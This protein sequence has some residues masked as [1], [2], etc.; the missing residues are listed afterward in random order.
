MKRRNLISLFAGVFMLLAGAWSDGY[1]QTASNGEVFVANDYRTSGPNNTIVVKWFA[2]KVYY[3]G[4]FDVYRREEG[5]TSWT[6]LNTDPVKVKTT[7]PQQLLDDK[8]AKAL[9]D[10]VNNTSYDE[11]QK[12]VGKVFVAIKAILTPLFAEQLGIIY[13]DASAEQ[14]RRYEYQVRGLSSGAEEIVNVSQ[15]ISPGSFQPQLP[16]QEVSV[17]RT[18]NGVAINWKPEELRYYGVYVYRRSAT[19]PTW[20]QLNALP[21][22][23]YKSEDQHGNETY[24][25]VFYLDTDIK[26]EESYEYKLNGVDFFGQLT[27]DTETFSAPVVDFHAPLSPVNL[28]TSINVMDLTLSWGIQPDEDL[29]GFRVYRS[30]HSDSTMRPV[31]AGLLSKETNSYTDRLLK[32]GGYYYEVAAVDSAGNEGRSQRIFIEVRDVTPPA[33]PKNVFVSPDTGRIVLTWR[34]NEEPDL[35]GY[36]VYRSIHDGNHHDDEFIVMNTTPLTTTTYTEILPKNVKT[37]FVYAVVAEDLSYNRSKL[38]DVSVVK[39]PDVTPPSKPVM[40]NIEVTDNTL[41][42]EWLP[43]ADTDLAGYN[44]FRS[45]DS[46]AFSKLNANPYPATSARFT[47][48]MIEANQRYYYYV[49][50][51][52]SAGNVSVPSNIYTALNKKLS[53]I[54]ITPSDVRAEYAKSGKQVKISW[55]LPGDRELVGAVI[56][57]SIDGENFR[58]VTGVIKTTDFADKEVKPGRT[59]YYQVRSY[60]S[61][62][63]VGKSETLVATI[64]E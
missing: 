13:Y 4:G 19:D 8:D 51:I 58:P 5:T 35:R 23:V 24:P 64:K 20:K 10:M 3:P 54:N 38:S 56:Y 6:K 49:Q 60:T 43:N 47:D 29:T 7:V 46:V 26:E 9:L 57:K 16:P 32:T 15:A 45:T 1:A 31:H 12:G 28:Q 62:G 52:D 39:M 63:A 53:S 25:E 27:G 17:S 50:A 37:K 42:L 22:A 14:G 30:P 44:I 40:K 18:S 48:R 61:S 41:I 2:N 55:R 36:Y 11:F 59:Y 34:A 33:P 21:R